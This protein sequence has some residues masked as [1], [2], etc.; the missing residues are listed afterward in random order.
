MLQ[1]H[2]L[3]AK[4]IKCDFYK[5]QIQYLGHIISK[6]GIVINQENIKS[7]EEWHTPTCVTDIRPFLG[8]VGYYDNFTKKFSRI[9]FPMTSLQKKV[10]KFLWMTKCEASFQNLKQLLNTTPIL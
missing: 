9:L 7:I 8:L 10:N 1:E 4:F 5:P 3:Y 6:K 2:Q